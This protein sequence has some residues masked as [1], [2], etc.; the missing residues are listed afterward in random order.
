VRRWGFTASLVVVEALTGAGLLGIIFGLLFV[1]GAILVWLQLLVRA[2][3]IYVLIVLAPLG[4]ATRAHPGTRQRAS[5]L[6]CEQSHR[7]TLR[8]LA[9]DRWHLPQ[10]VAVAEQAA[11]SRAPLRSPL[12]VQRREVD[13]GGRWLGQRQ[14]VAQGRLRPVPEDPSL[15]SRSQEVV[16][17]R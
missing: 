12:P 5:R 4:F 8:S 15:P 2:A 16:H 3:L 11:G 14:E 13:V 1:V 10:E 9:G 7:A 6:R 17:Q